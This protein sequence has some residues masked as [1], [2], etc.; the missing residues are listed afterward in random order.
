M[1]G[2]IRFY[3][4]R[5]NYDD[6]VLQ[7]LSEEIKDLADN[8]INIHKQKAVEFT[9]V[10]FI[11]LV[12]A[13]FWFSK[14]YFTKLGE[15]A[16]DSTVGAFSRLKDKI[17]ERLSQ[18]KD[19]TFPL[20]AIS[21]GI[22]STRVDGYIKTQDKQKFKQS[23]ELISLLHDDATD[24]L[25]SIKIGIKSVVFNLELSTSKWIPSYLITTDKEVFIFE[26]EE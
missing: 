26:Q 2:K 18:T 8:D 21:F 15:H 5:Q 13:L 25:N 24:L 11:L 6:A 10:V 4:N 22:G 9:A 12:N 16:A 14:G 23:L 20:V 1:N 17:G 19:G 3:Y 7:N